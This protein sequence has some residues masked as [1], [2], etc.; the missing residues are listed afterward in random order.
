MYHNRHRYFYLHADPEGI[1]PVAK[2]KNDEFHNIRKEYEETLVKDPPPPLK[3]A[4]KTKK[5]GNK[6][7]K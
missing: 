1:D 4:V 2:L 3:I 6:A 5:N 7:D